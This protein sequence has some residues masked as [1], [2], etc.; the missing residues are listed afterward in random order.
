MKTALSKGELRD[1]D[2]G[3]TNDILFEKKVEWTIYFGYEIMS[4]EKN[5]EKEIGSTPG[6]A[7]FCD[8]YDLDSYTPS[9]S[10]SS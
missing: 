7:N 8:I 6:A 4:N 10:N 1:T 9:I 2:S 5:G 3:R